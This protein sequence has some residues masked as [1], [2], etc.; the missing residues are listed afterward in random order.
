MSLP[1]KTSKEAG[2]VGSITI[3]GKGRR[4]RTVTLNWKAYK[5][6][7]IYQAAHPPVDDPHLFITKFGRGIG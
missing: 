3:R 5:A 7:R 4:T 6:V 1:V 2:H